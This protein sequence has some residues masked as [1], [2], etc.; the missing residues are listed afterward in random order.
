MLLNPA[1]RESKAIC[2]PSGD[3]RGEPAWLPPKLV[4]CT[5]LRP[6][7]SHTQI[8]RL[9]LRS[10]TKVM[11]FPS[12]ENCGLDSSRVEATSWLGSLAGAVES[13]PGARQILVSVL[14]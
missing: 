11:W 13:G 14:R 5:G 7:P 9:P 10:E 12:G 8:S 6:S 2:R 4:S 1:G 3:Q